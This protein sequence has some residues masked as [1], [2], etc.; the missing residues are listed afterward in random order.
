MARVAQSPPSTGLLERIIIIIE[1]VTASWL[2]LK[3]RPFFLIGL[4]E[5][6]ED[7]FLQY[8]GLECHLPPSITLCTGQHKHRLLHD[9]VHACLHHHCWPDS[10]RNHMVSVEA[11]GVLLYIPHP[12]LRAFF[13]LKAVLAPSYDYFM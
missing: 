13:V 9:C 8:A 6:S 3:M 10:E 11:E 12:R 4:T 7:F 1:V 2:V 5:P